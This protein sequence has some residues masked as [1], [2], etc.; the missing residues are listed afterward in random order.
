MNK[1]G[2]TFPRSKVSVC[3]FPGRNWFLESP[4]GVRS[5][6]LSEK[7][8]FSEKKQGLLWAAQSGMPRGEKKKSQEPKG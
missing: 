6:L 8:H 2:V 5:E 3:V 4:E 1:L 7:M